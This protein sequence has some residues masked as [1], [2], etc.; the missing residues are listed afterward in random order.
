[1][2]FTWGFVIGGFV[3][4]FIVLVVTCAIASGKIADII[5]E[6]DNPKHS[7]RRIRER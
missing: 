5:A 3:C 7:E 4:G 6:R 1:M 2:G